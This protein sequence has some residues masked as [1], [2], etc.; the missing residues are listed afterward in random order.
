VGARV[1]MLSMDVAE[2]MQGVAAYRGTLRGPDAS[3]FPW[4]VP[5]RSRARLH[6]GLHAAQTNLVGR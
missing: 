3:T 6:T 1:E 5:G 4:L 2:V